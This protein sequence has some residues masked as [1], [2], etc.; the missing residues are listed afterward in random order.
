MISNKDLFFFDARKRRLVRCFDCYIKFI[1]GEEDYD[2][3]M[4]EYDEIIRIDEEG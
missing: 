3:I 4:E 2:K 1:K